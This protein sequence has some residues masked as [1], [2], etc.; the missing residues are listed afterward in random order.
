MK[1]VLALVEVTVWVSSR[2]GR[3]RSVLL[4]IPISA[5]YEVV[6]KLLNS[7]QISKGMVLGIGK[8]YEI[9]VTENLH[10]WRL[11]DSVMYYMISCLLQQV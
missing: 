4:S 9:I 7:V 5:I 11:D 3:L 2:A 6:L 1:T 8:I 10:R